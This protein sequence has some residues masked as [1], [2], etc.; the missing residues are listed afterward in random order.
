[1][2]KGY[3]DNFKECK[4]YLRCNAELWDVTA[5]KGI[6]DGCRYVIMC[7]EDRDFCVREI[8]GNKEAI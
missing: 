2:C 4:N 6:T 8:S 5:Q 1:M 7:N 3:G